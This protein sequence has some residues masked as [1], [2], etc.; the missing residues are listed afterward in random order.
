MYDDLHEKDLCE[1]SREQLAKELGTPDMRPQ[2]FDQSWVAWLK[3][4]ELW[5]KVNIKHNDPENKVKNKK[6]TQT[7]MIDHIA[8]PE[9]IRIFGTFHVKEYKINKIGLIRKYIGTD[10][11]KYKEEFI[12]EVDLRP[13]L[14]KALKGGWF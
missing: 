8:D 11:K 4:I 3:R 12:V 7:Q 1:T 6:M 14:R 10:G 5:G 13:E 9:M 2:A